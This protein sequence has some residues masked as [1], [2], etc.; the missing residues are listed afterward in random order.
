MGIRASNVAARQE[1]AVFRIT[2]IEGKP[3]TLNG[4]ASRG[5]RE[6][7]QDATVRR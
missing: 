3:P 5:F 2:K 6:P 1:W 4:V 7:R